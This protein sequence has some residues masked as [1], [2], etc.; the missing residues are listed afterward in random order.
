M[1]CGNAIHKSF[2][3]FSSPLLRYH[4]GTKIYLNKINI[5]NTEN[6]API[7]DR[8]LC[9]LL[10]GECNKK[11][12][13]KNR[14]VNDFNNI[15]NYQETKYTI[16]NKKGK[17]DNLIQ[18]YSPYRKQDEYIN[19]PIKPLLLSSIANY[20]EKENNLH[21]YTLVYRNYFNNSNSVS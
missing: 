15:N 19:T 7:H 2:M 5:I 4:K 3:S 12:I 11:K 21:D 20:Q 6:N 17:W 13:N 10:N 9:Y 1:L 16:L 14:F 8:G 18:S